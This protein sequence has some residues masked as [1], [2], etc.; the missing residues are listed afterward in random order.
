MTL[1]RK[2]LTVFGALAL[3]S[4]LS[5]GL[6]IWST[7]NQHDLLEDLEA[8]YMQSLLLQRIRTTS[9]TLFRR[10]ALAALV[11]TPRGAAH[12]DN[13]DRQVRED[14]E[15]LAKHAT[16]EADRRMVSRV[17]RGYELVVTPLLEALPSAPDEDPDAPRELVRPAQE[18][19]QAYREML[20]ASLER[21]RHAREAIQARVGRLRETI[22]LAVAVSAFGTLCLV[23]LL[24]AYVGSDIFRPLRELEAA[25][26]AT[27]EGD[28]AQRLD[29]EREDELG[30]VM[31]AFHRVVDAIAH[32]PGGHGGAA[33]SAVSPLLEMSPADLRRMLYDAVGAIH[34]ELSD[35]SIGVAVEAPLDVPLVRADRGRLREALELLVEDALASLPEGGRLWLRLGA[36]GDGPDRV[37]VEVAHDGPASAALD[38]PADSSPPGGAAARAA[39]LARVRSVA[40]AHGG[41]L[42]VQVVPGQGQRVAL[43]LP[44]VVERSRP[45]G[46]ATA[47]RPPV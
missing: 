34:R 10:Q 23:L 6:T 26:H 27:A 37:V 5:A 15:A 13:L 32:G 9:G 11:E 17:Q 38:E 47:A 12:F 7:V 31:R 39:R 1:R 44:A 43:E 18:G 35:R 36:Q 22:L 24:A 14:L 20:D 33:E 29:A 19:V 28:L 3:M 4:L 25:L 16:R 2:L 42:D 41:L 8:Q 21:N 46:D 40:D 45:T 30:G